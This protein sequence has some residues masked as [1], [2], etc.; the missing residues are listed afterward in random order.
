MLFDGNSDIPLIAFY[1]A[2]KDKVPRLL[3]NISVQTS[4][5]DEYRIVQVPIKDLR[6]TLQL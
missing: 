1:F 3:Q 6:K 2:E 4:V 5:L